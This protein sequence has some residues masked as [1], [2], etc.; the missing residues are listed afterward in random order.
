MSE[1]EV[2]NAVPA[3][4]PSGEGL[5]VEADA[6]Q[7]LRR[8]NWRSRLQIVFS[9]IRRPFSFLNRVLKRFAGGLAL[10]AVLLGGTG[11]Y[12]GIGPYLNYQNSD[13]VH[14]GY[15]QPRSVEDLVNKTQAS[16]VTV[17]CETG[18]KSGIQGTAF[19][20]ELETNVQ[21]VYPTTLITNHHV[22]K[23][24]INVD[25]KI[26][27][28][29]LYEKPRKAVL[30]KWDKKNDLA[31]LATKLKVPTLPLSDNYPFPG[32]WVMAYGSADGYE[33]SVAFGN[34]VNTTYRDIFFTNNV[35]H[36]SSGGPLVDNEGRVLGMITWGDIREQYN[37]AITLDVM[38][39]NIL[40][41]HYRNG[42]NWW[43]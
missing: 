5:A 1:D 40:T 2:A 7:K 6:V 17:W 11:V 38:C 21:F 31:V 36:G 30:V 20:I 29:L 42:K 28:A 34:V 26:S 27:V 16:T 9:L 24:C 41:C 43:K 35:S 19:A 39:K 23:K 10:V 33:G 14:D 25:G 8:S 12:L 13:P 32:Y 22:I 3:P 4:E 37:G 18:P 15:V